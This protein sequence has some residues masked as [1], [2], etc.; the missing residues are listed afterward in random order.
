MLPYA[1]GDDVIRC[2]EIVRKELANKDIVVD[3]D[4]LQEITEDIMGIS[5]AKGGDY[6]DAIIQSFA[7]T[8]IMYEM[9]KKFTEKKS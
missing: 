3:E 2:I 6:S 1:T 4:V 7:R 9:Y 8:Y 5:Y